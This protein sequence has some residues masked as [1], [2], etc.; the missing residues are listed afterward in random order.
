M[1]YKIK[2]NELTTEAKSKYQAKL[3][4]KAMGLNGIKTTDIR[5]VR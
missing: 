1:K 3:A 2:Y 5:R 4:F